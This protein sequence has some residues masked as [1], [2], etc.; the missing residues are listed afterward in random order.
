LI[1][2]P[3]GFA[4][5]EEAAKAAVLSGAPALVICSTDDTYPE[6]VAPFIKAVRALKPDMTIILAGYPKEQVEQYK[7]EGVD[8]FIFMGA[9]VH[10]IISTLMKKIGVL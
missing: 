1:I 4:S 9:D 5:P 3:E 2:Y 6:L 10:Q 7:Q 8:E